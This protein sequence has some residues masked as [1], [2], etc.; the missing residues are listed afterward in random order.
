M[1]RV[2][3]Q[4]WFFPALVLVSMQKWHFQLVSDIFPCMDT[5]MTPCEFEGLHRFNLGE[6]ICMSVSLQHVK[7]YLTWTAFHTWLLHVI[8]HILWNCFGLGPWIFGLSPTIS[9]SGIVQTLLYNLLDILFCGFLGPGVAS[10]SPWKCNEY[11]FKILSPVDPVMIK[12]K[13]WSWLWWWFGHSEIYDDEDDGH[14]M[15]IVE[16][17]PKE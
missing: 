14:H 7:V 12:Y 16:K 11:T 15:K 2:R 9:V 3:S 4:H 1:E 8:H 17:V 6:V 13:R 10:Y 5:H